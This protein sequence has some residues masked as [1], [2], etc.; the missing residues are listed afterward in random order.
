M[1][2]TTRYTRHEKNAQARDR[3]N[4]AFHEHALKEI[5]P[6]YEAKHAKYKKALLDQI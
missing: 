6:N 1:T 4:K 2:S 5:A 3:T